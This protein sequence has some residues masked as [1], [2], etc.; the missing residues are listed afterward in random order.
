MAA[1]GMEG[2]S[3]LWKV[4]LLK[5]DSFVS[6]SP[7]APAS[8]NVPSTFGGDG[9]RLGCLVQNNRGLSNDVV[10]LSIWEFRLSISA[11]KGTRELRFSVLVVHILWGQRQQGGGQKATSL[12]IQATVR[13]NVWGGL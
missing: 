2:L 7:S 9:K 6:A 11:S 12:C 10:T 1:R 5:K 3:D 4:T 13:G 8:A